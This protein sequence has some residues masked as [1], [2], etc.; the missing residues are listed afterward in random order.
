MPQT[1]LAAKMWPIMKDLFIVT[2]V[3][4]LKKDLQYVLYAIHCIIESFSPF[5]DD[6]LV[7]SLF[8]RE[9]LLHTG[10]TQ[11]IFDSGEN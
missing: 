2:S 4:C 9:G 5:P 7:L 3:A 11:E 1:K 6:F 8:S 10:R